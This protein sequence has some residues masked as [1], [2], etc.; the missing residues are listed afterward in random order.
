[1]EE[2]GR[3]EEST[4]KDRWLKYREE[5]RVGRS[6]WGLVTPKSEKTK[7][8]D[9]NLREK[10]DI[11]KLPKCT[12]TLLPSLYFLSGHGIKHNRKFIMFDYGSA[13]AIA[14]M[15]AYGSLRPLDLR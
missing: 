9:R 10:E 8:R 2:F 11:H 13:A 3:D 4:L 1:M 12:Q 15:E 5:R 6:V 14:N 7:K